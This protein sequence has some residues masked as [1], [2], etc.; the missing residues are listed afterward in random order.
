MRTA[1]AISGSY[2]ASTQADAR[3]WLVNRL[4][5]AMPQN[6]NLLDWADKWFSNPKS[7][8]RVT[9]VPGTNFSTWVPTTEDPNGPGTISYNITTGYKKLWITKEG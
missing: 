1:T 4:Q 7:D 8:G 5:T 9:D 2:S 3:L 6:G